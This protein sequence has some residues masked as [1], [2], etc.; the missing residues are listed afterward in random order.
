MKELI[1]T[2]KMELY[3]AGLFSET[4]LQIRTEPVIPSGEDSCISQHIGETAGRADTGGT[5]G[6]C[7]FGNAVASLCVEKKVRSRQCRSL[8]RWNAEL[9]RNRIHKP[10]AELYLNCEAI[11]FMSMSDL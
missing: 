10:V 5:E 3:G 2:A 7:T 8:H 4:E 1:F 11:V 9:Q 6:I